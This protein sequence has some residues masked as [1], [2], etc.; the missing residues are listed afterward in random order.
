VERQRRVLTDRIQ[1]RT[2][3]VTHRVVPPLPDGEFGEAALQ[4]PG[5]LGLA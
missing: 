5:E 1:T 4:L 2:H 3:G